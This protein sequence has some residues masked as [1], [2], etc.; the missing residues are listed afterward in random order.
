MEW[1]WFLLEDDEEEEKVVVV[2]VSSELELSCPEG[3]N[4]VV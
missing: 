4:A 2:T 1:C 3:K